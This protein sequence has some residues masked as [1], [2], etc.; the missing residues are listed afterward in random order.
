MSTLYQ[1][2]REAVHLYN[3]VLPLKFF[4]ALACGVWYLFIIGVQSLGVFKLYRHYLSIPKAAISPTLEI[5][6]VPNVTI[7][8]PVKGKEPFL[9]D[10]L[11]AT[12]RQNY[13]REK[14]A[15]YFCV[16]DA[17]DPA[18]PILRQ[19]LHNFSGFNARIFIEEDDFLFDSKDSEKPKLGPNPKIRNLRRGYLEAKSDIIWILDCN[20]WVAP[21]VTGRMV[22]KLCGFAAD[23]TSNVPYKLVHQL[24]L[25]V[26]TVETPLS[27]K[28]G[29]SPIVI[30]SESKNGSCSTDSNHKTNPSRVQPDA[31]MSLQFE[32]FGG[33]L[34]EAFMGSSHAKFYTAINTVSVAPC[35]VGK[36]NM[37][38]KS[39]LNYLT[40]HDVYSNGLDNFSHYICEDH[41]IGDVIWKKKVLEE[42]SGRKFHRHGLVVGD[43]AIQPIA[44]MSISNYIRRRV[45]WLR[46]RKWTVLLATLVE[47]GVEPLLCSV[48]GAYALTSLPWAQKYLGIPPTSLG[49]LA[50]WAFSVSTWMLLDTITFYKLHSGRTIEFD[51]H[52]PSFVCEQLLNWASNR[53]PITQ[54]ILAWIGREILA[55]PIWIWACLCG[56]TV[57][58]RGKKYRIN[59]NMT[60]TEELIHPPQKRKLDR[61]TRTSEV[62]TMNNLSHKY[63]ID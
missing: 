60:M 28:T 57:V 32:N 18:I 40:R 1:T 44:G 26:D 42:K 39:H 62:E 56:N 19:L 3:E 50:V 38:R 61:D 35:I 33:R 11:A 59:Y 17:N 12:F 6:H 37:F 5:D 49:F 29:T 41:I 54:W 24:P 13:P 51:A 15:V 10:C 8:R 14:L 7:L 36:S 52:T 21:G 55:L 48:H 47:P 34:E 23:G 63:R 25:I 58:W 16:S 31:Q 46:A 45:R 43:L 4:L 22:D 27:S 20:V 53:R 2:A 9:Y 30:G